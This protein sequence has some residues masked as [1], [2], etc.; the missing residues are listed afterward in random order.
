MPNS[1]QKLMLLVLTISTV[2]IVAH[3]VRAQEPFPVT[4]DSLF[5]T[6]YADG[7]VVVEFTVYVDPSVAKITVSPPGLIYE[8]LIITNE[9]GHL[10]DYAI[11]DGALLVDTLGSQKLM[12]TYTTTDLTN[13]L[14]RIWSLSVNSTIAF[15]VTLPANSTIIALSTAPSS[16]GTMD[17]HYYLIMPA[18]KQEI[19]Y[20]VG[21]I[22]SKESALFA[23]GQAEQAVAKAKS[24][25]ADVT[26][27][28]AKL[29]DAKAALEKERYAEAELLATDAKRLADEALSKVAIYQLPL[30]FIALVTTVGIVAALLYIFYER[31]KA[32]KKQETVVRQID[33]DRILEEHKYMR[34]E[35][36]EAIKI[37]GS[38][39]GE[40]FESNLR[41]QL[42]LPKS[43]AWRLVRRLQKE[44]LIEVEK[45]GGQNLI[46]I[47]YRGESFG[48]N[49]TR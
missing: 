46:R 37:I 33:V 49:E 35:D 25:G 44:G 45:V 42:K 36:Q 48:S 47:I 26:Q 11:V 14:G 24:S 18:G 40:I 29:S 30:N 28:E 32:P 31:Q 21:I 39:G 13:K 15:T 8:D 2:L 17:G 27:A 41:E 1:S 34:Q 12:L 23:I 20:V 9:E 16:I 6:V 4:P 10:I 38:A 19:N 7:S 5:L 22:G 3:T 43:S